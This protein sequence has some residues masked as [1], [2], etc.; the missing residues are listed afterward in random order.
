[1]S[2][3]DLEHHLRFKIYMKEQR[4]SA[5][6]WFPVVCIWKIVWLTFFACFLGVPASF[7]SFFG[8]LP[9]WVGIITILLVYIG[10][11]YVIVKDTWIKTCNHIDSMVK[12]EIDSYKKYY[13]KEAKKAIKHPEPEDIDL[14]LPEPD[15]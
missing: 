2:N 13:E 11:L 1:M 10:F 9:K 15:T 4:D 14:I 5:V 8:L 7:K 12:D 6:L 3:D